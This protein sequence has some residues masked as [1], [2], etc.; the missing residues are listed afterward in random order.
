[1]GCRA[2]LEFLGVRVWVVCSFR[3]LVFGVFRL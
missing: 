2:S 3:F 1:M